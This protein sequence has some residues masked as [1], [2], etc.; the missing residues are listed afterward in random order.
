MKKYKW[1]LESWTK[2]PISQH[3][4]W[5]NKNLIN[6]ITSKIK[7]NPPLVLKNEILLLKNRLK[8]AYNNGYYIIQGGDCAERFTDFN[9][10]LIKNKLN[11]L[12]QMS[13]VLS[14]GTSKKTIRIGRI[15]GQFAKPRTSQIELVNNIEY[16]SYR[17]DAINGLSCTQE[18]RMPDPRRMIKAYEQSSFTLNLIRSM[19]NSGYTNILN[20]NQWDIDFIKKSPQIKKYNNII[21]KIKRAL[22]F[23]E[24]VDSQINKENRIGLFDTV[25]KKKELVREFYDNK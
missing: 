25:I 11:I 17:G 22:S 20:A 4:G 1:N 2:Q 7:R 16:P 19:I 13:V 8:S 23:I 18:S 12:L 10:Q 15:A 5:C 14:Y 21:D 24:T 6:S 9:S 3:P